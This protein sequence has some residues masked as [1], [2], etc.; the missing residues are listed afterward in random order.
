MVVV[1]RMRTSDK[2]LILSVSTVVLY[3]VIIIIIPDAVSPVTNVYDWLLDVTSYAGYQ[4]SLLISFLGNATILF[5]FPY[6]GVPFILG[7]LRNGLTNEFLFDPW[8]L[9]LVS[10][11]GAMLGEMTGY[12][13]G[14]GGGAMIE[15]EQR[16]SFKDFVQ[17]YPRLTPIVLW[18]L[19]ATPIPDDV[20]VVPLG[21][22]K[23]P[24]WKVAIPQLL[25]KSVFLLAIAW[26]GRLGLS[27]I[28]DFLG[29]VDPTSIVTKSAEVAGFLLVIFAVYTMVRVDW[30][31]VPRRVRRSEVTLEN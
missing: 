26:A 12:V 6:V 11:L 3:W 31:G 22:A 18:F 15:A 14:Y 5:P 21:A 27:W 2:L 9:G 10:G 19:A 28:G 17:H 29:S 25:G 13:V 8:L 7:G 1:F 16:N 4:G 20:L 24:W 23:Y 30:A